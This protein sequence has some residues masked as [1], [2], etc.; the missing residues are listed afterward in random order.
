MHV[1]TIRVRGA[2]VIFACMAAILLAGCGSTDGSGN[3]L[4]S[5]S[6]ASSGSGRPVEVPKGQ[7]MKNSRGESIT[8]TDVQTN[9]AAHGV[10]TPAT[11]DQCI[12]VSVALNNGSSGD[13]ESVQTDV[14]VIDSAGKK[15]APEFSGGGSVCPGTAAPLILPAGHQDTAKLTFDVPSSGTLELNWTPALLGGESYQTPLS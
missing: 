12:L 15:H 13:W 10:T 9:Y 14:S 3:P 1:P 7:A 4:S 2:A 6:S 8:V 5:S 11:G